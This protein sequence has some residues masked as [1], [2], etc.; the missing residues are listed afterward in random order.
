M[1]LVELG[2]HLPY[3]ERVSNTLI[4]K[5][6]HWKAVGTAKIPAMPVQCTNDKYY[7]PNS[8]DAL[9]EDNLEVAEDKVEA[10]IQ[11]E[12]LVHKVIYI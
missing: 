2:C 5:G 6:L 3:K 1:T 8:K 10:Y 9:T 12:A 7:L 11:K 4:H